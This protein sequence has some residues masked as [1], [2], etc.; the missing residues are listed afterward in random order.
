MV[1]D[2]DKVWIGLEYFCDEGDQLWNTPDDNFIKLAIDEM[3]KIG[4]VDKQDV[5]D[6]VVIK[7]PKAYPA[8]S[9]LTNISMSSVS[10]P[11]G[12]ITFFS[13]AEQECTDTTT[14]TIQ[15]SLRWLPLKYYQ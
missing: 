4:I 8:I 1:K 15:C 9:A 3:T 7:M 2:E 13:S 6:A 14:R 10:S 11:T 12:S 5:L